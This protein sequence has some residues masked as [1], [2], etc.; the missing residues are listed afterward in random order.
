MSEF[1]LPALQE[2][3]AGVVPERTAITWR[4]TVLTH[5]DFLDQSWRFAEV[6]A[7][8]GIGGEPA[9]PSRL[10]SRRWQSAFPR[11]A[12]IMRN[13]PEWLVAMF[14]A[15]GARTVPCNINYRYVAGEMRQ[16][17][18]LLR[19]EVVVYEDAFDDAV[20]QTLSLIDA[21]PKVTLRVGSSPAP[22]PHQDFAGALAS[23]SLRRPE[24]RPSPD[25]HY[26]MLTGGTTGLPKAVL[27]RQ[28]DIFFASMGGR[29]MKSGAEFDSEE[30]ITG[31]IAPSARPALLSAPFMH[32]AAQWG[33]CSALLT[34]DTVVIPD[35]IG[36]FD[37][38]DVLS[39]VAKHG[40]RILQIVGN[41]HARPLL[42]AMA[43]RTYDLT[44][45]RIITTGAVGLSAELKRELLAAIPSAWILDTAG[46]TET[47][48]QLA[49]RT[50]GND[51]SV[52][53]SFQ[54]MVGTCI[55]E[56]SKTRR[57]DPGDRS[58]G[59]LA[60][61][62]RVPLG[63]LN[64]ER[65]TCETFPIVG[66]ERYAIPGDRARYCDDGSIELLG[67]DSVTINTGGEK[68]FVEEV[69]QA[70][71]RLPQVYDVVVV[72]RPSERWGQE[73]V[74]IVRRRVGVSA[75]AHQIREAIRPALAGYKIPKSIIFVDEIKRSP[76]GKPDYRWAAALAAEHSKVPAEEMKQ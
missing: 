65:A 73:V 42:D 46:A 74:A 52:K 64:D 26:V 37:P 44:S 49:Q 6:L 61:T 63:Y 45:L 59:W 27:W 11:V 62:G 28:A 8:H 30:S 14:G 5:R 76:A 54:P 47:G 35:Q 48:T 39:A 23:V 56:D 32:G 25:D 51:T 57:L 70:I 7:Q 60:R 38:D 24:S 17:L 2:L 4:D 10:P 50:H 40:V 21:P 58:V 43:E 12:I 34:G 55:L 68:V 31:R 18:D 66:D 33:A 19:P 41:A 3:V 36:H 72:G 22:N 29:D 53:G 69:E 20:T 71:A 15:F 16:V 1:S 75:E 9:A 13:R 67:R